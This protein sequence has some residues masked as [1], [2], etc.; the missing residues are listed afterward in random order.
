LHHTSTVGRSNDSPSRTRCQRRSF[1]RLEN[2][3][4]RGHGAA[5]RATSTR[6][7]KHTVIAFDRIDHPVL[8]E[9]DKHPRNV[10]V[11]P[12]PPRPGC[13]ATP[14]LAKPRPAPATYTINAPCPIKRGE[15]QV[16][17]LSESYFDETMS[18]MSEEKRDPRLSFDAAAEIYSEIRPHYPEDM[19]RDLFQ[20]LPKQPEIVEVGPGTRQATG[21]LLKHGA[22]VTAVEL[23]PRLATK[24]EQVVTSDRLSVVVGNFEAV[25][26]PE[27][28]YDAVFSATAYHW[29]S[30]TAQLDRPTQLL[31]HD[32]VL[33]VVDLIQVASPDDNGFFAAT[34]FIYDRYGEGHKGPPAPKRGEVE[35]AMATSLRLDQ[36]FRDV[37]VRTYDWNQ[38]YT[39]E[40]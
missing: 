36:R 15:P 32:G 16:S 22:T 37:Q 5:S 6:T 10:T 12:R 1:T 8:V 29:I 11:Q 30:P 14:R 18:R 9:T 7:S 28:G 38:T 20:L 31:R 17:L 2:V 39:A 40:Q 25:Q 27:Y 33:A 3:P 4:R 26:L 34:Q 35:P 24:L 23:G 21:D 13:V 19:F